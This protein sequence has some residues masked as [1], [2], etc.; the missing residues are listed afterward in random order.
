MR[1]SL[2]RLLEMLADGHELT[3]PEF[4][5]FSDLDRPAAA[6][7]R[8]RWQGLPVATRALL[9]ERAGELADVHLDRNFEALGKLAL[10]DPEPEVRER[11]VAVFWESRDSSVARRLAVLAVDDIGSGV[12]AAA[13]LTL[14]GF[15]EAVETAELDSV[16]A[17]AVTSALRTAA[18][19]P[20][21]GVR[22]AALEA[23][24]ALTQDWVAERILDAYE[25]DERELR[26]AAIRA[27]G[28]SAQERWTEYL[29]D[30][31][32]SGEVEM[33]LEAV[34]AA[35]ALGSETL[36]APLGEALAD[37]D[38]E[39][40][41]AV[42]EAL[43]EIGG[44]AAVD[45]LNEFAPDAPEGMEEALESALGLAADTQMFRRFG[46]PVAEDE[47]DE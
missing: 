26:V 7:V 33:R 35:G 44:E 6:L 20:V 14:E 8:E 13:A 32:Y 47:D 27:M 12:R 28:A 18:D 19:D 9:L 46:E 23:A 3:V 17:A 16:T 37:D 24:G 41:L 43:G 45:L 22:A 1:E 31:L 15:V 10:D 34:L 40:V 2:A 5:A 30:Q 4:G 39:V 36:V 42:I 11:A 21:V 25:S 29:A 38:P